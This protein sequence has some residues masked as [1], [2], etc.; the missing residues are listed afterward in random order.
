MEIDS[1]SRKKDEPIMAGTD[2]AMVMAKR[3]NTASHR[4][5]PPAP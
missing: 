5:H 4:E 1:G 3:K 2:I